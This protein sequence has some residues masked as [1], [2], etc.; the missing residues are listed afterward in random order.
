MKLFRTLLTSIPALLILC[1]V[2]LLNS[3]EVPTDPTPTNQ[4]MEG[5]WQMTSITENGFEQI[6]EIAGFFPQYIQMDDV[7]SV[8]ST[9]GPF[10]MY[11]VYGKSKFISISSKMDEVFKYA[12]MQLTEGEWFI[13]KNKVVDNFTVEIKMKFPTMQTLT[14]IFQIF[15]LDLPEVVDDA[16]G[17]VIYHK[18]KFVGVYVD[19]NN[20]DV[21]VW[22]FEDAVQASFNTKDQYGD[23]IAYNGIDVNTFSKCTVTFERKVKSLTDLVTEATSH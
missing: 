20:P 16:M 7:N 3:C 13:D 1:G 12:D 14:E 18:F 17:L 6:D 8:N 9:M 19:D 2:M 10:F 23:N 22:T 21:M 11:L 15:H 5:V 4:L